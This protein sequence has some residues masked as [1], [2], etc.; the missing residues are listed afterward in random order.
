[1]LGRRSG[2][3]AATAVRHQG[4][5][6]DITDKTSGYSDF[7]P[8]ARPVRQGSTACAMVFRPN[9]LLLRA[10]RFFDKAVLTP[11]PKTW[12]STTTLPRQIHALGETMHHLR[13]R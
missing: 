12:I 5:R 1:M 9:G 6:L 2:Q 8:L 3:T 7:T 10:S 13:H 4:S 11:T